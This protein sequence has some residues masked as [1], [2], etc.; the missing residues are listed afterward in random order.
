MAYFRIFAPGCACFLATSQI[1]PDFFAA[2][3]VPCWTSSFGNLTELLTI[4]FIIV[5]ANF[6]AKAPVSQ[7]YCQA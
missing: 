1:R 2:A 6:G 5:A 4:D 3:L 7:D